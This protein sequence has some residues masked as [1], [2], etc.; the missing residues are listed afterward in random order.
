MIFSFYDSALVFVHP[1]LASLSPP[2]VFPLELHDPERFAAFQ[3]Q[4]FP[5]RSDQAAGRAHPLCP[6]GW[7]RGLNHPEQPRERTQDVSDP[8][9]KTIATATLTH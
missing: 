8:A 4:W 6:A 5:S 3:T 1:R 7:R 2:G 9:A